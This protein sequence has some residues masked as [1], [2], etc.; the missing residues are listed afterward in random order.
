[1]KD[2]FWPMLWVM[3]TRLLPTTGVEWP[4]S[5]NAV[6]QR[7]TWIS[8][9]LYVFLRGCVYR[10]ADSAPGAERPPALKWAAMSSALSARS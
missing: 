10:F 3:N 9:R 8:P 7:K 1:M 2:R 4:A 5:G 6:R